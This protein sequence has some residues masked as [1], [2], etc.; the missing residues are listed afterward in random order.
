MS[1][2][3]QGFFS[4]VAKEGDWIDISSIGF[5]KQSVQIPEGLKEPSYIKIIALQNDTILFNPVN[6]YPL[7][8]RSKFKEAFM[9]VKI[10]KTYQEI[11][12]ENFNRITMQMMMGKLLPDAGEAQNRA[13]RDYS[14]QAATKGITPTLGIGAN[15]PFGSVQGYTPKKPDKPPVKW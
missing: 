8:S 11:M 2:N 14:N 10:N 15:I 6:I 13:L 1:A 3:L 4:L 9:T 5:K 7:P 12:N